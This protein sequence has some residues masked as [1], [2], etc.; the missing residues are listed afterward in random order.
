[1]EC[2]DNMTQ[3]EWASLSDGVTIQHRAFKCG[4][5]GMKVGCGS[6]EFILYG[7]KEDLYGCGSGQSSS[8]IC[9]KCGASLLPGLGIYRDMDIVSRSVLGDGMW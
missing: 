5:A 2:G 9:V 3:D 7:V 1:M 8:S 4:D 6:R